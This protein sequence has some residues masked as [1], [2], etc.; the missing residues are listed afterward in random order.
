MSGRTEERTN[1]RESFPRERSYSVRLLSLRRVSTIFLQHLQHRWH[2]SVEVATARR[3]AAGALA[4][5]LAGRT[6]GGSGIEL[7]SKR[8]V[9]PV[10]CRSFEQGERRQRREGAGLVWMIASLGG[11]PAGRPAGWLLGSR[12][13]SGYLGHLYCLDTFY[14]SAA[15]TASTIFLDLISAHWPNPTP[16]IT[17]GIPIGKRLRWS[18]SY[19][20]LSSSLARCCCCYCCFRA[21][22]VVAVVAAPTR[23][24][25]LLMLLL[26][27][28]PL[29][30]PQSVRP[31]FPSNR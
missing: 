18:W 19:Q 13:R 23:L 29:L 22:V 21:R 14:S 17:C 1:K 7:F 8:L 25:R 31:V 15:V 12:R 20:S 28:L 11:R 2:R 10:G 5:W 3:G 26:L 6:G 4:G 30:M 9:T 16:V 24:P 27:L